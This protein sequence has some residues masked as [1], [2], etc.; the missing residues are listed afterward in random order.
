MSNPSGPLLIFDSGLGG[1]TVLKEIR[2]AAPSAPLVYAADTAVFPY[3]A[4]DEA[5]LVGRVVEVMDRLID[6]FDPCL[7]VIACNTASTLVL[8]VLR[9]RY[10]IPFV[11]T[12]PAIKP[13]AQ[14]TETGLISV[15]ATPG[16]VKRDYTRDLIAQFAADKSVTLVGAAGLA[17]LA[18]TKMRH[19]RADLT[20]IK[21]EIREAFVEHQGKKTDVVVLACTHFPLLMDELIKVAPWPVTWI[22]PAEAIAR[23]AASVAA[24]C[25]CDWREGAAPV[26]RAVFTSRPAQEAGLIDVLARAGLP[27]PE[28]WP[29]PLGPAAKAM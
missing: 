28:Y 15:L 5:V 12:V 6:K 27:E 22:D 17:A 18:E 7:C 11:G 13:A 19:G 29:V 16:T 14:A 24:D 3:G 1:L 23:R 10:R 2:A 20:A 21:T 26:H 9:Q 4:L 8:P 25:G